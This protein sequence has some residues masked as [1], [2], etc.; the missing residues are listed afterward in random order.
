MLDKVTLKN[1]IKEIFEFEATQED[2][3]AAS[4]ER[5]AQK[6]SDAFDKFVKSGEGIYQVGTLKAGTTVVTAL[7]STIVKIQ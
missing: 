5:I 3:P 4:R 1:D 6:L 2:D 7:P